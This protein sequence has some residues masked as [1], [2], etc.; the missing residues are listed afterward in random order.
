MNVWSG[1]FYIREYFIIT[2]MNSVFKI[3]YI[4]YISVLTLM[5]GRSFCTF[6]NLN[7]CDFSFVIHFSTRF[8]RGGG[9]GGGGPMCLV[10]FFVYDGLSLSRGHCVKSSECVKL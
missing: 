7:I 1:I 2:C 5:E 8:F 10:S 3:L 4:F 9:G 6:K